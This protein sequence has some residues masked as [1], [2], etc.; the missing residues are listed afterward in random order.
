MVL[1]GG[2]EVTGGAGLLFEYEN[3]KKIMKSAP[4]R[5]GASR[6]CVTISR[7]ARPGRPTSKTRSILLKPAKMRPPS[8]PKARQY[9]AV[10][11][12]TLLYAR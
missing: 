12:S 5:P 2:A 4:C 7:Y 3:V 8:A 9:A 1:L 11:S 10:T 6:L